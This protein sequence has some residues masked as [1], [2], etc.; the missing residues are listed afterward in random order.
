LFWSTHVLF[1]TPI[2]LCTGF[3]LSTDAR[4]PRAVT[5]LSVAVLFSLYHEGAR[6][7]EKKRADQQGVDVTGFVTDRWVHAGQILF[8]LCTY[9]DMMRLGVL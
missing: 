2:F 3:D 6:K 5:S 8:L 7:L 9:Q 1:T 4:D